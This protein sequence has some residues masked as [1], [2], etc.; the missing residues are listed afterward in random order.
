MK[1]SLIQWNKVPLIEVLEYEQ[2]T[3]YIVTTEIKKS[4][5][6]PV[7]TPGKSFIKGYTDEKE[8]IFTNIPVIIFDDF[9]TATKF[10]NFDFKVKSSAMK[11]LKEKS[12][13]I[14]LKYVFYQMQTI[15]INTSSHKRYYL[16]KYQHL[17]FVF[18]YLDGKIS[19]E[20][21]QQIVDEIEKQLTRLDDSINT[22]KDI[23][24]KL[25][26]YGKSVLKAA[27]EGKLIKL[28]GDI[29]S[30]TLAEEFEIIMGQS[31]ES[32]HYNTNKEGLPFF[33]GKK[34]FTKL[35]AKVQQW[36]RKV[37]KIAEKDDVLLSV[38]APIGPVNLAPCKCGVGRGLAAIK[39]NEKTNSK[40]IYYL[41]KIHETELG[42]RGTGTTFRAITKPK[43]YGLPIKIPDKK[44]DRD[45]LF[46][47]IESRFS[48][49][50]KL[51]ETIENSLNK[52]EQLRKS[53]LKAA[54]EGKLIKGE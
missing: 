16:S 47:E 40:L 51:E 12:S 43:L 45:I 49:I 38:R 11:I 3:P 44:E 35:Y 33:Q 31:P 52:S 24:K 15:D 19:K 13:D 18:P 9:T 17:P 29:I 37:T 25:G 30:T 46:K 6:T 4:G 39:P 53:I 27:F 32:S 54:F 50:E 23:K 48:V 21:Q 10:V 28:T 7:L 26:I 8:G 14:N 1:L 5:K 2:P 22:F 34:E 41:L 20:V 36:S 42:K